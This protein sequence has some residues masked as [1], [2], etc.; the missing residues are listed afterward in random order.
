MLSKQDR[1]DKVTVHKTV[2]VKQM[3]VNP[4]VNYTVSSV[5]STVANSTNYHHKLLKP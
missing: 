2:T 5:N 1:A 3:E 4:K